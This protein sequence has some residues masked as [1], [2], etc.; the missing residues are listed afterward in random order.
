[1]PVGWFAREMSCLGDFQYDMEPMIVDG[2]FS[3]R[4]KTA[5]LVGLRCSMSNRSVWK[6]P[7][8]NTLLTNFS[9]FTQSV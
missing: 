8:S 2:R 3:K 5:P 7:L 9:F 6:H 1:M 4:V